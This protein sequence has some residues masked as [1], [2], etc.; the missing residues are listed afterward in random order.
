MRE[1][2]ILI[3]L[4]RKIAEL[5]GE[6]ARRNSDFG[7]R[8]DSILAEIPV[9]KK[10]TAKRADVV[11][12]SE[13]PD[14]FNEWKSRPYNDFILW[15]KNQPLIVLRSLIKTHEL[16]VGKRSSKWKD[17]ERIAQFIAEQ[18][19]NRT[20]RGAAFLIADPP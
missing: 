10:S 13:L 17:P 20:N 1:E 19:R 8:L 9:R 15:L 6:E 5:I 14:I 18:M 16:D 2:K 4:F 12:T 11:I 3:R 7:A